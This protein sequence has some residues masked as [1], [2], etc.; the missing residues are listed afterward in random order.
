GDYEKAIEI[1][2]QGLSA[3]QDGE[4]TFYGNIGQFYL[5][6]SRYDEAIGALSKAL[7]STSTP[8]EKA[9]AYYN[10]AAAYLAQLNGLKVDDSRNGSELQNKKETLL[11][12]AEETLLKSIDSDRNYLQAWDSYINVT[13]DQGRQEIVR[14]HLRQRIRENPQNALYGL[15]KLAF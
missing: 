4:L 14:A 6:H 12:Q 9:R 7:A 10:I 11:S 13:V 8:T 3:V 5:E 2:K 15:G 1:S